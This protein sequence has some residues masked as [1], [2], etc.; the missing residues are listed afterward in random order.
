MDLFDEMTRHLSLEPFKPNTYSPLAL[1]YIGDS[2]YDLTIRTII[3]NAGNKAVGRM[4][5]EASSYVNANTQARIYFKV[6]E[7]LTE[8]EQAVFKRGRNAKSGSAPK[9]ADLATY[10]HATGFEAVLGWLYLKGERA[11]IFELMAIGLKALE[12]E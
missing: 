11:R 10:K 7:H 12:E 4:H 6:A 8:E 2:I 5:K 3:M 1:A 9:N